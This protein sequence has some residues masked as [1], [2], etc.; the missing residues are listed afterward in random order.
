MRHFIEEHAE[1]AARGARIEKTGFIIENVSRR[2]ILGGI[3]TTTGLVMSLRMLAPT[4]AKA[5][6]LYPH[7]GLGM[8][9][10]V[11]MD[12]KVFVA[13]DKDG[14]VTIVA[15]RSEMGTGARTALPMIIADEMEA[16]WAR[17]KIV[18]APGDEPRYGNQ[19]TDGSRSVRHYIQPMRVI[20]ASMKQML[21]TVAALKWG[22][23]RSLCKASN[24]KVIQYTKDGKETGKIYT[25]GELAEAATNRAV[26]DIET[27]E[28][29]KPAEF[30]Y[31]VK[32]PVKIVDLF[33]ITVGAAKYGADVRVPGLKYAVM[34]RPPVI[35]AKL[36][37]FD[38]ADA[39][40]V[41]GVE[42]VYEIEGKAPPAKFA[43]LGGVA[44]VARNT[45]AAM[46]GRDALKLE[47][48]YGPHASYNSVA[49]HKEME[50]TANKPGKVI[51]NLGDPDAAFASAKEVVSATYHQQHVAQASMETPV[52]IA[53]FANGKIDVWAPLQS[54]YGSRKDI[55]D[56][57]KV[58]EQNVTVNVTLL[59]GGFGRKSK[60]DYAL[61]AVELSK[62]SNGAPVM[63]L[64]T[65][66]DDIRN[67][68]YHTTSCEHLDAA[69]D[70]SGKVTAWRH[71]SVAP[72][73]LSTFAPDSGYQ[74]NL[75]YGMGL[76]DVPVEVPN[77][78]CENGQAMAHTR[79]G[80]FRSVSNIPRA[81]AVQS[82]IC[83]LAHKLGKDPKDFLLEIIG[84][85]RKVDLKA[86]GMPDDFWNYG[87]PYDQFPIDTSRLKRVIATAADK[88]GWGKK[89]PE[90]QGMGIAGHR[91]FASYVASVVHVSI[92]KDGVVRV[93]EVTTAIDC[94]MYV[95]PERIRSQ[96]EGAAVMAMS[97]AL[98][99][100]ITFKDGIVEQSNF[101]DFEVAR[102]SNYPKKVNVHIL[103]PAS[104]EHHTSGVGEPGVP[105]FAPAL[106]N[107]IFAA[108]GKRVRNLP[109]GE[110]LQNA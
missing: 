82:F 64:W 15:H 50:E 80:W 45:Y 44:V 2:S 8:P 92:D 103:E 70:D 21:E 17:V 88:A 46:A 99:S 37:S 76:V 54:P 57:Y 85:D 67:G 100:G 23:D 43:S 58:A 29:K 11:V 79:I 49:Y 25:F 3:L 83:E 109:M 72:S 105:P 66:E 28:F 71:R 94:G 84:S 34:A 104:P 7:G 81:F 52:A 98:Y 19:D 69:I 90:G 26:P 65:R 95:H 32:N 78:R 74:F 24:H 108:S 30:R 12:P 18:Q 47:W 5:V 20:G 97:T 73:I 14:T 51:R 55:C 31:M 93:P 22:V 106:A 87:E 38:P 107:A 63:L 96:I 56:T 27:V 101:S 36:K 10:G 59:G 41:P 68:F 6:T 33:D 1:A 110:K 9:N 16:D 48:D 13:L 89:L 91:C 42:A 35:G 77:I 53:Q 62:R 39:L 102:I 86:A 60:C 61:E 4:E 40:K 75:E